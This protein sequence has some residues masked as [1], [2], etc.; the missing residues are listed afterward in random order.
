MLPFALLDNEY[1]VAKRGV[2]P[3][4]ES[5]PNEKFRRYAYVQCFVVKTLIVEGTLMPGRGKGLDRDR[6][7]IDEYDIDALFEGAI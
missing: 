3:L 4:N 2:N 6:W 5:H 7:W 1:F